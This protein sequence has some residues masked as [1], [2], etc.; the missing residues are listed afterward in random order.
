MRQWRFAPEGAMPRGEKTEAFQLRFRPALLK[1]LEE[2]ASAD[3][4]SIAALMRQLAERHVR[5]VRLSK[6]IT[7]HDDFETIIRKE[8]EFEQ[9]HKSGG[10]ND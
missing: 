9:Q 10:T 3:G 5:S 7:D 4:L 8:R 1:E 2:I 6:M